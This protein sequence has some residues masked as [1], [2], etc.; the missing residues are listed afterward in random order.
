MLQNIFAAN[1]RLFG[2]MLKRLASKLPTQSLLVTNRVTV[3]NHEVTLLKVGAKKK[4][5]LTNI[6]ANSELSVHV[7]LICGAF[8]ELRYLCRNNRTEW[9]NIR[10]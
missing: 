2:Q 3:I 8:K 10:G 1:K 7:D 5:I 6:L 9:R 4:I